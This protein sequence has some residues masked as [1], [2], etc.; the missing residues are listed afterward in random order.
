MSYT[1]IKAIITSVVVAISLFSLSA[2]SKAQLNTDRIMNIGRNA[3]YFEDYILAIQYFNQ[4]IKVKPYMAEPYFFRAV[5]KIRLEDYKGAEADCDISIGYNPFIID[6]YR[7]RGAARQSRGDYKGAIEDYTKG[8]EYMPEDKYFLLQKAIAEAED[9]QYAEADSTYSLL[10]KYNPSFYE[11]YIS[12]SQFHIERK[13]TLS[14]IKDIDKALE[15]DK[16]SSYGYAMRALLRFQFMHETDSAIMDMDEAIKL[17]PKMSGYYINR[18]VMRYYAENLR[19]AMDDYTHVTEV[20]PMNV[21]AWYNRGLLRIH[22]GEYNDAANDFTNV[23]KLEPNNIFAYY[24]RA[25][26]RERIG[27]YRGAIA[28]FTKVIEAYPDYAGAYYAR[29]EAKRKSGDIAGG[30]ADYTKALALADAEK[31][32][33]VSTDTGNDSDNNEKVRKESDK[34]INKFDR[35]LVADNFTDIN[36]E[37]DS[38]IR[39]RVQDRNMKVE[40]EPAFTL[41]Y[42]EAESKISTGHKYNRTLDELNRSGLLPRRLY[43]TNREAPLDSVMIARHFNSINDNS[44]LIEIN[45]NNLIPYLARAIDFIL[46]QDYTG[47]IEDLSRITASGGDFFFAYFLRAVVRYRYIEYLISSNGGNSD[48]YITVSAGSSMSG[49]KSIDINDR[50]INLEYEMVLRDYDKVIAMAPDFPYSY[51]NRGNIRCEQKDFTAAL[52]DYSKAIELY[53]DF[54]E[55]YLNRGLVYVYMGE[56]EK[57]VAD[58]S[59][60]GELG[61]VSAYNILKRIGE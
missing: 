34:N 4:V 1:K 7:V 22:V 19:G 30:K 20:D 55:A 35:L 51:F 60:A 29:S 38:E 49:V 17:D 59:K 47:A 50:T 12:R 58:L 25:I 3:L 5:A 39:G 40:L 52:A 11:A 48:K 53:P 57:S 45:P 43:L 61:I 26:I 36:G 14:A 56:N 21:Q 33:P 46:I 42:Y 15:I 32:K 23:I 54:A 6:A 16:Y 13:D 27:E 18:A 44:K 8:L 41:T 9:E 31:N 24:N 28:D 2:T 37:Y 10:L